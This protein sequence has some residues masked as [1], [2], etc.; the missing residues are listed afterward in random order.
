[1]TLRRLLLAGGVILAVIG[2][3]WLSPERARQRPATAVAAATEAPEPPPLA[4]RDYPS[5]P[6][7]AA[8]APPRADRATAT[9]PAPV[10]APAPAPVWRAGDDRPAPAPQLAAAWATDYRDAVCA[11]HT[12]TCVGDVQGAFVRRLNTMVQGDEDDVLKYTEATR[13]AL[14]CYFALPEGS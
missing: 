14:K 12:R 6:A 7:A 13:A 4:R 9:P 8:P 1:M 2:A 5:A 10:Q 11:C 3:V